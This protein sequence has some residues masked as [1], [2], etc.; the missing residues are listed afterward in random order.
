MN[1][2][3]VKKTLSAHRHSLDKHFVRFAVKKLGQNAMKFLKPQ[4]VV[5]D[6]YY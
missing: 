4:Y 3:H 5:V 2:H 6:A 1:R